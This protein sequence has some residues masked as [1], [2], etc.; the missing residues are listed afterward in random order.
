MTIW[1]KCHLPI[2]YL[3]F[4]FFVVVV[5]DSCGGGVV[6]P[7]A[8][9]E[10][11]GDGRKQI[12]TSKFSDISLSRKERWSCKSEGGRRWVGAWSRRWGPQS[13][14]CGSSVWGTR[15]NGSG[16]LGVTIG[17]RNCF[18]IWKL[19]GVECEN[20]G[21]FCRIRRRGR[22]R[23]RGHW[24]LGFVWGLGY[25]GVAYMGNDS[26]C[27]M[28]GIGLV[29]IKMFDGVIRKLN[30]VRYVPDLKKNLIFLGV[31]DVSGYRIIL[32][33]GNLK[34]AHGALE[35][36]KG[37]RRG[38]IYYLNGTTI[39]GHAVMAHETWACWWEGASDIG[40]PRSP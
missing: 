20:A 17:I 27:K 23:G 10:T 40:E 8:A 37:T 4:V 16:W 21:G 35:A 5:V 32:E 33:G 29:Q 28:T 7:G 26:T 18:G 2:Y 25:G 1:N 13:W 3:L 22:L 31:L 34:V 39:V 15:L 14:F 36:I 9:V 12:S 24:R 30:D 6:I 38:S 19:R 11:V